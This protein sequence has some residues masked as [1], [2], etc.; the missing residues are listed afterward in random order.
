MSL[1]DIEVRVR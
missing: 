1:A